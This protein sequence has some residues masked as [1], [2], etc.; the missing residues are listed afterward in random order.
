MIQ[1]N[2]DCDFAGHEGLLSGHKYLGKGR[3]SG[4]AESTKIFKN[5]S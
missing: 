1:K 5:N 3:N 4:Q 2:N